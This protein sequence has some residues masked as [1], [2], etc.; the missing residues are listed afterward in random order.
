M[1]SEIRTRALLTGWI[2][3]LVVSLSGQQ[4]LNVA[5]SQSEAA[6]MTLQYSIGEL[7]VRQT[8]PGHFR[9][10]EGVIQPINSF[11]TNISEPASRQNI[12]VFPNPSFGYVHLRSPDLL[13]IDYTLITGSGQMVMN[14]RLPDGSGVLSVWHL[15][16]G[17]YVLHLKGPNRSYGPIK[18]VFRNNSF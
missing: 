18:I 1:M 3:F 13:P 14:D 5:G 6:G 9:L 10:T 16:D 15:P 4:V 2:L 7:L 17:W 12:E 11:P 8:G